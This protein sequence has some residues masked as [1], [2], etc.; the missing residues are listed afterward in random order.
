MTDT[1]HEPPNSPPDASGRE[2]EDP[3][4]TPGDP[5]YSP[6]QMQ[7]EATQLMTAA[8]SG[9]AEAFETLFLRVR[10]SAFQ[11][12][13]S[14]VGSHEDALDMTQ[15]AFIKAYRA[16]ESYDPA[17]PFLPW[18]HRIL[19]N[20]CFSFLRKRGRIS[21]RSIH[22]VDEYGEDA[23][24]D[25]VDVDAP[26]PSA[27]AEQAERAEIFAEALEKL[28]ARDRGIIVLRHYQDLSYKDISA[29]LAI[30]EGTVMSRLFHAR[31]RLR[32]LLTSEVDDLMGTK[33]ST[34]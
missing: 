30:P 19:R 5:E 4:N 33:P 32:S 29:A 27:R 13:R 9:S 23:S 16:R 3:S 26:A 1:P 2:T 31:K 10:G 7:C 14:L 6:S 21:K 11:A 28:S 34:M 15:E 8:R 17:Q 25:I 20:T 24:W 22:A 18:F 12:A